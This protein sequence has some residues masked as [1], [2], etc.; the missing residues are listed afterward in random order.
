MK[1]YEGVEIKFHTLLS[2]VLDGFEWSASRPGRCN[3]GEKAPGLHIELEER[4][5]QSRSGC[6]DEKEHSCPC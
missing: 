4:G 6:G 5:I 3:A 2:L 1:T